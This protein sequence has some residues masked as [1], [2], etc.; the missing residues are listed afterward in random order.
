[1]LVA[2]S[3]LHLFPLLNGMSIRKNS[4]HFRHICHTFLAWCYADE[5]WRNRRGGECPQRLLTGKFLL[6]CR[7][8]R[9][10]EKREKWWKLRRKRRTIVK[11][12]VEN[13]KKGRW[14]SYKMIFSLSLHFSKP[15][16][17]VLVLPKWKFSTGKK[18]FTPG[19][20][21]SKNDFAPSE[22]NF[23]VTPLQNR[24]KDCVR[25]LQKHKS[26]SSQL[27][28]YMSMNGYVGCYPH[29]PAKLD[30]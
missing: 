17:F 10:K 23:P 20:K 30:I 2:H 25:H 9:G 8:K 3:W 13:E 26:N 14:K 28:I 1:M 15:L 4:S 19:K 6:T 24:L 12:N 22:K 27:T 29:V 5:Q 7:E 16:K 21:I 11:G 18:H